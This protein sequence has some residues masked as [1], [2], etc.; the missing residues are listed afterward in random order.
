MLWETSICFQ[1]TCL[2]RNLPNILINHPVTKT[3]Y[4]ILGESTLRAASSK[5]LVVQLNLDTTSL[6]LVHNFRGK[7]G[8]Q[9]YGTLDQFLIPATKVPFNLDVAELIYQGFLDKGLL[10]DSRFQQSMN[11]SVQDMRDDRDFVSRNA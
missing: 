2:S 11:V 6:S 8:G 3:E 5:D 4:N 9:V 7:V 1:L 10:K